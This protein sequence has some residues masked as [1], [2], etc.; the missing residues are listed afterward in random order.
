[1]IIRDFEIDIDPPLVTHSICSCYGTKSFDV[2]HPTKEGFRLRHRCIESDR[3]I[4]VYRHKLT[5]AQGLNRFPF[6]E[7]WIMNDEPMAWV[8]PYPHRGRGWAD[9]E[10]GQLLVDSSKA[11]IYFVWLTGLRNDNMPRDEYAQYGV[12]YEQDEI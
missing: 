9:V 11:G 7:W 3:A 1:M 8:S 12:E 10:D 6:P 5:C 2:P 4:N